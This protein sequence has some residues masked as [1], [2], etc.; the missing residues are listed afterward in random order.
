MGIAMLKVWNKLK[1]LKGDLKQ[2]NNQEFSSSG[3]KIQVA[4]NK[5]E[6][7]QAQMTIPGNDNEAK[8]HIGRLINNAGQIL[9]S[10][11]EV[12]GHTE[13]LQ[14][15]TWYSNF[16]I[17]SGHPRDHVQ[18]G[19][20]LSRQQKLQLIKLVT[21]EEGKKAILDINNI[22]APGY[23]G[24]NS[25]FFKKTWYILG[26]KVTA[27]VM[28]FFENVEMCKAINCCTTITLIPKVKNPTSIKEFMPIS[29]C[30]V[31]YK[32]IS[33]VLTARL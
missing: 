23:D 19:Y 6:G 24:Y 20:M 16:T 2:L 9:Q 29:C 26:D 27:A 15:A 3:H 12:R 14:K 7:T 25:Y 4:R 21:R 30:I 31:L 33:K 32:I 17:T 28:E 1:M 8:N 5:L 22:K 13:F 18:S 11:N 10:T